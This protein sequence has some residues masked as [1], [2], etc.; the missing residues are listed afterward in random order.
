MFVRILICPGLIYLIFPLD[1]NEC[2]SGHDCAVQA[3]CTNN[4][5]SYECA[6]RKGWTGNGTNCD[7]MY[8][9]FL[10]FNLI[11]KVKC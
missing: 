11:F 5:G 7:G 2:D 10:C 1:I 4:P 9:I 3:V 8:W 6:C